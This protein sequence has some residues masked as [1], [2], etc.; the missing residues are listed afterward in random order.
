MPAK[1]ENRAEHLTD[2]LENLM[3]EHEDIRKLCDPKVTF[4]LPVAQKIYELA[5]LCV[6]DKPKKRPFI[7]DIKDKI[8]MLS[9][10]AATFGNKCQVCMDRQAV[11]ACD[12][13]HVCICSNDIDNMKQFGKCPLCNDKCST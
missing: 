10:I 1:D 11:Y 2:Y 5:L 4:P 8:E 3:D 12:R 13:G 7:A 9:T 6:E